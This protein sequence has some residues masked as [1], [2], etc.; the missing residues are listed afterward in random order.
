MSKKSTLIEI[1]PDKILLDENG[2]PL[3]Q[4]R[5][6]I[7]ENKTIVKKKKLIESR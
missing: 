3:E 7:G 1:D 2:Q 5:E 6:V 4:L